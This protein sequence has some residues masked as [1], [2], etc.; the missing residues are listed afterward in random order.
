MT[1]VTRKEILHPQ[2]YYKG[3]GEHSV[4]ELENI[5]DQF[6]AYTSYL[7]GEL[8]AQKEKLLDTSIELLEALEEYLYVSGYN[9]QESTAFKKAEAAINKAKTII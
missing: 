9:Y 6:K 5:C 2:P 8:T 7:N 4:N 1:Q 3:R